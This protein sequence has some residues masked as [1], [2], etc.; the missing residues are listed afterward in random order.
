MMDRKIDVNSFNDPTIAALS[1]GLIYFIYFIA[2]TVVG[3]M[4]GVRFSATFSSVSVWVAASL[5]IA[6]AAIWPHVR[7]LLA[8]KR[9]EKIDRRFL[10]AALLVFGAG[11]LLSASINRPD[12]D[13]SIY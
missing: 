6:C 11:G 5:L 12:I 4:V 3:L 9:R 10:V 1:L 13:D 2:L 8:D 7:E